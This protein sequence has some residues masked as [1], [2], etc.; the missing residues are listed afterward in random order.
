MKTIN[1]TLLLIAIWIVPII[2]FAQEDDVCGMSF[3]EVE[4]TYSK[5]I[6]SNIQPNY[7]YPLHLTRTQPGFAGRL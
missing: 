5:S 6:S 1:L 4:E 3:I 7:Q 2:S